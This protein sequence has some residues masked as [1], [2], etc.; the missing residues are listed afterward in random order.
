MSSVATA[1][2]SAPA[3][4]RVPRWRRAAFPYALLL[5]SA[6]PV[7]LFVVAM[8]SLLL[9]SFHEFSGGRVL[10]PYSIETWREFL[11]SGYYWSVVRTTVELGLIVTIIALLLA[12]PTAYVLLRLRS[13]TLRVI[14][15]LI[16]FSPLLV[17]IVVR[18]YGWMLLL[19][20]R[21]FVNQVLQHVP[22][23]DAPYRLLFNQAGVTIALVH[24]LLPFAVFP[25]LSVLRQVPPGVSEA[26]SDLGAKPWRIWLKVI[27]PLSMPGI[28][29]S[30]QIVF[31]L[32]ISAWATV[33]LLGGG[34]VQVLGNM[35]YANITELNWPLGAVEAFVLLTI[36]LLALG[37]LGRL[38]RAVH[39][40]ER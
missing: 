37:M 8:L 24:I 14:A 27:L 5:P 10:E 9:K 39:V 6:L 4:D 28:V 26:A 18:T 3:S 21:G 11:T 32:T 17:S 13:G 25:I 12:Y 40:A 36:A 30:A 2:A 20:E 29:A 33:V 1:S 22:G 31:T 35:I 16:L 7:A 15:Y 19:G 23:L 38:G 34:R